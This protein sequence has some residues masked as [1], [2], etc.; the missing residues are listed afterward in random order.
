[1]T[2]LGNSSSSAQSGVVGSP[3]KG[4]LRVFLKDED[5]ADKTIKEIEKKKRFSEAEF[6]AVAAS[7][8][9]YAD[10]NI[11][12]DV[13]GNNVKDL[14]NATNNIKD[15]IKNIEGIQEVSTNQDEKKTVYS[16]VVDPSK[17]TLKW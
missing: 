12:I 3:T 10:T 9:G 8:T 15:K 1:M 17:G 2:Y 6:T 5:D 13:T 14:E 7:V 16:F 11:T 4:Q